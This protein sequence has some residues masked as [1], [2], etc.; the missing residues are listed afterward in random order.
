MIAQ[1]Q[2]EITKA[3]AFFQ[4]SA[5]LGQG[6]SVESIYYWSWILATHPEAQLRDGAKAVKLAMQICQ[7]TQNRAPRYL[8]ALAAA[9]AE[10]G[11]YD[12][13]VAIATEAKRLAT[14]AD[15]QD[16]AWQITQRINLYQ[17]HQP[18]HDTHLK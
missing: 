14:L 10:V 3:I 2:G 6:A 13:A 8:D 16:L 5:Q 11:Q 18:Y 9:F 7:H 1:K 12:Q 15:F 17:T 4:A